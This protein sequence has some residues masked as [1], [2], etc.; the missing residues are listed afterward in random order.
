MDSRPFLSI[1]VGAALICASVLVSALSYLQLKTREEPRPAAPVASAESAVPDLASVVTAR[2]AIKRGER[3]SAEM[4]SDLRVEPPLPPSALRDAAEVVN[5]VALQDISQGQIV[6]EGSVLL[7][8]AATPGLSLLVPD[9][10]RAV[11]L[12]VDDEV[13]VG[14]FIRPNDRVDIHL[15]LPSDRVARVQGLDIR[16]GDHTVS[17]VLL[18]NV[19]ILS[20]GPTLATLDGQNAVPMTNVTVAVSPDDALLLAIA[21]D[22]GKFYLALRN[23]ADEIAVDAGRRHLVDLLA[24]FAYPVAKGPSAPEREPSAA[25]APRRDRTVTVVRGSEETVETMAPDD[26]S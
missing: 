3:V 13:S 9:G 14:K 7:D 10:L 5:A 23:P 22:A 16:Q 4:L 12:R 19:L 1:A 8:A 20:A 21:K 11:A 6:T 18:Q 25:Q 26:P 17:R 24:P 2:R 15:V